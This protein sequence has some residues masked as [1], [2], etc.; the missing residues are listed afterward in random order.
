MAQ[1]RYWVYIV[2][3]SSGTIYIGITSK[4]YVR[5][6]QHKTGEVEGF[7]AKYKCNRLVY[8]ESFDI[9]QIAS[10]REKQLKGWRRSKK[11]ALIETMNPGWED[12]AEK[13]GA[14]VAFAG[15]SI[16]DR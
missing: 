11:T 6:I 14:Q 12:L 4:L 5:I 8:V 13:W 16:R 7:S 15:E 9:V 2:A 10:G 3:S 1:K